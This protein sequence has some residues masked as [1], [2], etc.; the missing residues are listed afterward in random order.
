M[1]Q[2]CNRPNAAR[3]QAKQVYRLE[4]EYEGWTHHFH[5][6]VRRDDLHTFVVIGE[7]PTLLGG[8]SGTIRR[9]AVLNHVLR[10]TVV[11]W[12]NERVIFG[13]T[14]WLAERS[15]R[16]WRAIRRINVSPT[17]CEVTPWWFPRVVA[18]PLLRMLERSVPPPN[19]HAEA[20]NY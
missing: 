19:D 20:A 1:T 12:A 13:E 2:S 10:T 18:E 17:G 4:V 16:E 5:L 15:S 3:V 14:R 11:D 9:T 7:L 6:A 8:A